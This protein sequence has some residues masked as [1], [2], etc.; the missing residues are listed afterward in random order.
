LPKYTKAHS[1]LKL[2]QLA[3]K[4]LSPDSTLRKLV[5]SEPDE[6]PRHLIEGKISIYAKLLEDE[7]AL[8]AESI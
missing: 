7:L 1:T 3:E 2:K 4:T 5:L 6:L 8:K